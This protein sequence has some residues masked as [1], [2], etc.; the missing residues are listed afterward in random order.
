MALQINYMLPS[1]PSL[2][3]ISPMDQG[4]HSVHNMSDI[5]RTMHRDIFL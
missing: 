2:S 5:Q 1:L 4:M 3:T